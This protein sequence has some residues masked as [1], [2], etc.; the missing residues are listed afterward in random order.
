M[1][2][3]KPFLI[4]L[5]EPEI[6]RTI[7]SSYGRNYKSCCNN[8]FKKTNAEPPCINC[9]TKVPRP[10]E[11][12]QDCRVVGTDA[13]P[14][15][16]GRTRKKPNSERPRTPGVCCRVSRHLSQRMTVPIRTT[17]G[18]SS[19]KP[20][21]PEPSV[22]PRDRNLVGWRVAVCMRLTLAK[23]SLGELLMHKFGSLLIRVYVPVTGGS[24]PSSATD[25]EEAAKKVNEKI[26]LRMEVKS[27]GGREN[28]YLTRKKI[29]RIPRTSQ[30]S[31]PKMIWRSSR[32]RESRS[33]KNTSKEIDRGHGN[34]RP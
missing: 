31:S 26:V 23:R 24:G 2:V 5:L 32:K 30:F 33:P 25:A 16:W 15:A 10:L 14:P 3:V 12:L 1:D 29:S 19:R 4:R 7:E 22:R 11:V 13:F 6:E 21:L 8:W 28:R 18:D 9:S 34:G 20:D 17:D 27:T